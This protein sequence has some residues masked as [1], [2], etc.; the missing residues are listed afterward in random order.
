MRL[1]GFNFKKINAEKLSE[2]AQNLKINTGIDISEIREVKSTFFKTK[3]EMIAVSFD[4][5][6]S[7][8]PGFAKLNFAGNV[9]LGVDPKK[10]KEILK[11]WK[12]EKVPEDFRLAVF[13][14]ILKKSSLRALQLGEEMNLPPHFPLPSIKFNK[15]SEETASTSESSE[16]NEQT[17]KKS[18]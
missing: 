1:I 15:D 13:N 12:E 3:E 4:Y 2:N 9:L 16:S 7:Y 8:E 5:N 17:P 14:I 18:E 10:S 6:I 11:M